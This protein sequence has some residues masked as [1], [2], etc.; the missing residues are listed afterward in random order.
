MQFTDVRLG[1]FANVFFGV[2]SSLYITLDGGPRVRPVTPFFIF[3][4]YHRYSLTIYRWQ[5]FNSSY[6]GV[7]TDID[8]K[9]FF[10]FKFFIIC[11]LSNIRTT[12]FYRSTRTIYD[13]SCYWW[14]FLV[15]MSTN[16]RRSSL[17]QMY[18]TSLFV[19]GKY[20]KGSWPKYRNSCA[21]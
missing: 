16:Q 2:V 7:N 12:F 14:K 3:C 11:F 8:Q 21:L 20:Q 18:K 17:V 13:R 4:S 1:I 15:Y 5:A 19:K 9:A 6:C 10:L